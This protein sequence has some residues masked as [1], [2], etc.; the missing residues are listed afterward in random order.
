[1]ENIYNFRFDRNRRPLV[2]ERLKRDNFLCQG[3]GGG[4]Q[5]G[6]SLLLEGGDFV[7][8]GKRHCNDFARQCMDRYEHLQTTRI[9][10]NL[11]HIQLFRDGD[12][13]VVP[14]LPQNGKVSVHVVDG[15]FPECYS[16]MS[17]DPAH[18]NHR[19]KIKA[20]YGLDGQ[21]SIYDSRL[22][23]WYGKLQWMRL[24]V[25][26]KNEYRG[27]F[28][29]IIGTLEREPDTEFRRSELGDYLA[30]ITERM[31]VVLHGELKELS[32]SNSAISFEKVCEQL[33]VDHGYT[34]VGRNQ[35]NREG[36]DIDLRC[37]RERSNLTPFEGG[38]VT[39]FVQIKKHTGTT[40]VAAV[41]QL[42]SMMTDEP[43][44]DG[45][46]MSLADDFTPDA[47]KL[48]ED[49]G[50]LLLNGDSIRRLLLQSLGKRLTIAE[51]DA[52][53]DG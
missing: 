21:V 35:F 15:D 6:L 14:H 29:D 25:L 19:I 12:W 52:P 34:V 36:G 33:I 30:Q 53:A 1:M 18:L 49:N 16:Y 13:L 51:G 43:E 46:V 9:P 2:L 37:V 24:P 28:S 5:G 38:E 32:P 44:A 26:P 50:V 11:T 45:C 22:A 48:A 41:K 7:W 4:E 39:L 27:I 17:S 8:Q 20:S 23:P 31:L 47:K 42:L 3:W 10:T 40:D